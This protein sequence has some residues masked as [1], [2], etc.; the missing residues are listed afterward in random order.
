M[1]DYTFEFLNDPPFSNVYEFEKI[2]SDFLA[3]RGLEGQTIKALDGGQGRRVILITKKE[4]I[5]GMHEEKAPV[6]RPQTLK[7]KIKEL[8]DRKF[9]KPAI[10]FMK[11]NR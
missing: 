11:G 8:S 9:R 5:Q 2:F 7:G 4:V 1:V 6:G 3:T 10:D